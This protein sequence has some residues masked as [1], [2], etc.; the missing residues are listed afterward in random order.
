MKRCSNCGAKNLNDAN[1]CI[2]CDCE[3]P[4]DE[5]GGNRHPLNGKIKWLVLG[6][7]LLCLIVFAYNR[8]FTPEKQVK[9]AVTSS[10]DA[11]AEEILTLDSISG[12]LETMEQISEDGKYTMSLGMVSTDQDV[13]W[14]MDYDRKEKNIA[15]QIDYRAPAG[16]GSVDLRFYV[17]NQDVRIS[18]PQ[19]V[20]DIYGFDLD[21]FSKKY[22]K[23]ILR[24][25]LGL[26]SAKKLKLDLY[27][28]FKWDKVLK[29]NAGD[30][31]TDFTS[32]IDVELF[33]QR[34]IMLG[35]E[36]VACT[37][38]KV[39]W[40]AAAADKLLRTISGGGILTLPIDL[41][42]LLPNMEPDCRLYVDG[43]GKWVGG[44][45]ILGDSKYILLLE[46]KQ[47]VWDNVT[48]EIQPMVGENRKYAGGLTVKNDKLSLTLRDANEVFLNVSYDDVTGAFSARTKAGTLLAGSVTSKNGRN[49]LTI[50]GTLAGV[51]KLTFDLK[52]G[53]LTGEVETLSGKYVDLMNMSLKEWERII[54]EV[55][56]N[57]GIE[58]AIPGM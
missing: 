21:V 38:Y 36:G 17:D 57:L 29:L 16:A 5:T 10:S 13:S 48:L 8:L 53:T 37:V 2:S 4:D 40:S 51:E 56:N 49:H 47:N 6:A 15:G 45:M 12:F 43:E 30:S 23:S 55:K 54:I 24:S 42:T 7:A 3:L 35:G 18:A 31:W 41:I 1:Y 46:G 33:S 27:K 11:V 14:S 9:D 32:T 58:L 22:D 44:D 52:V 20:D 39:T 19:I 28:P 26:P 25:I 34:E 50:D